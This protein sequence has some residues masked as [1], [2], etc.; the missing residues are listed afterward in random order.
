[1]SYNVYGLYMN[2]ILQTR[3]YLS[4]L[5][6]ESFVSAGLPLQE[7]I[8]AARQRPLGLHEYG[9]AAK[10]LIQE[11]RSENSGPTLNSGSHRPKSIRLRIRSDG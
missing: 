5:S 8:E 10:V 11:L 3:N 9:A 7:M 2:P 1:M 4:D 6:N